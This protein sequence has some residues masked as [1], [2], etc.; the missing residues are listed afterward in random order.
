M[1]R[2]VVTRGPRFGFLLLAGSVLAVSMSACSGKEEAQTAVD[3]NKDVVVYSARAEHLIKPLFTQYMQETGAKITWLTDK[4]G[5]LL[6]RIKAEGDRTPADLFMTVDAGNLWKAAD[7]GVL[8]SADSQALDAAVPEAYRDSEGRWYG[9]SLRSRTLVY[10]TNKVKPEE[11]SSYAGLADPQ[12]KGRL[13]LRTSKKVYNQSLVALMIQRFG[14][15]KTE[16]IVRGWVANLAVPPFSNDTKAMQAVAEGVC[17]VTLVNTYYF[18]RLQKKSPDL[19]L[20]IAWPGQ[21]EDGTGV[22]MNVSG[23]GIVKHADNAAGARALLEWLASPA[24][25]AKFAGLNMEFPVRADV[26]LDPVVARWGSFKADTLRVA[27][28]GRLQPQAVML[29]DRAGWK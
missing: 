16:E 11:L 15:A 23:A 12:W 10:N 5:P 17:D 14:E 26:A 9:L 6:E 21:A 29:M 27:D 2:S 13:C 19:P 3:H 8:Q 20:A 4:E 25:Q 22:H 1:H 28:A 18:G 7:E 24:A